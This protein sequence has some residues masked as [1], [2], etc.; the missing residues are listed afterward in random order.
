MQMKTFR[1]A[2]VLAAL[3]V[4]FV[5]RV[6]GQLLV[7]AHAAPAWMPPFAQWQSGLLP[8]PLLVV[9]QIGIIIL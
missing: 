1:T 8:Y 5:G 2:S 4:A 7:A 3:Q 6:G 9:A